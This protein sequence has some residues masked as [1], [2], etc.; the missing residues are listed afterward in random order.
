MRKT[1]IICTLGPAVDNPDILEKLMLAGMD[2]A[3]INFSHGNYEEQ[4]D[5]IERV[6]EV[7]SHFITT[8]FCFASSRYML[9]PNECRFW[10]NASCPQSCGAH[11]FVYFPSIYAKLFV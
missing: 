7:R 11:F 1:K 9:S 10:S 3:R 5:R 8:R 2:V 4:Q 6:K